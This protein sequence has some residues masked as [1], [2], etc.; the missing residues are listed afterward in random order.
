MAKSNK[1]AMVEV[2]GR[3][4]ADRPHPMELLSIDASSSPI[5]LAHLREQTCGDAGLAREVIVMLADQ[6]AMAERQLPSLS[7]EGRVR[8]AHGL[9]GAARNVGAFRLAAAADWMEARPFEAD[10]LAAFVGEM[11]LAR[12]MAVE[13][14]RSS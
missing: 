13:L 12:Q 1:K 4:V 2:S 6:I 8:L 3:S 7:P 10:A 14:S 5:D 9:K 11:D